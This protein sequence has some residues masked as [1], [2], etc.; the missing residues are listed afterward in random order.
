VNK[1]RDNN[2]LFNIEDLQ[3]ETIAIGTFDGKIFHPNVRYEIDIRSIIPDIIRVISNYMSHKTY[4]TMFSD[5]TLT[6]H[7]KLTSR[8]LE[9]INEY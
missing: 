2:G 8:D 3:K 9:R 6:R 1:L 7:N 5:V 4:T